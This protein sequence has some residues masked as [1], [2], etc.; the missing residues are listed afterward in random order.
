VLG[1]TQSAG[2]ASVLGPAPLFRLRG[3]E[4]AQVLVKAP[5]RRAAVDAVR[6]AVEAVAGERGGRGVAF[7]VDVDPQ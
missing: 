1:L 3:H 7:S 4:R 2:G 6:A 5:E